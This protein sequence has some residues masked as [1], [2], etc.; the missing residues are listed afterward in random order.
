MAADHIANSY[1]EA[2]QRRLEDNEKRFEDLG[3]SK[4]SKCLSHLSKSEKITRRLSAKPR[5]RIDCTLEP[6]RSPRT[7]NSIPSYRE[8]VDV[9]LPPSRKR[10]KSDSSWTR[11][12]NEVRTASYEE[13]VQAI[14]SAE[15][16]QRS[17]QSRNPSFVK[18]MVRSHVYS[19]FLV[20]ASFQ[21][22]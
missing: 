7:R 13:R 4:I 15:E 19:L 17:L 16:L 1:E 18:S 6:R 20:G 21:I 10:S 12:L 11:P 9:G 14:K 8:D 5:S 2:R 22:L 3:I